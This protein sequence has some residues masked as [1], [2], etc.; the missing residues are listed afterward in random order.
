M[1]TTKYK[2]AVESA[3]WFH[4]PTS[5]QA[6]QKVAYALALVPE[7]FPT[8]VTLIQVEFERHRRKLKVSI[9]VLLRTNAMVS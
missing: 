7:R 4:I 8:K 9:N 3:P 5:S 6:A 1:Q 2:Q